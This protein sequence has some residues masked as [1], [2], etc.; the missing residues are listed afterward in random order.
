MTP[1]HALILGAKYHLDIGQNKITFLPVY[2]WKSDVFFN[3]D[4]DRFDGIVDERQS[5]YGVLDTKLIFLP[6]TKKWRFEAHARNVT[7]KRYL[8]DAGN[9]GGIFG[10][11]TFIAAPPRTYGVSVS[12]SF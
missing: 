1:K 2:S 8:L 3:N 5:S 11:P 12:Y 6:K 7:N 4:N 9:V 10:I